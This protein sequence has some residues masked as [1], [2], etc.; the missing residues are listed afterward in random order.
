MERWGVDKEHDKCAACK[1]PQK[2]V[3]IANKGFPEWELEFRLDRKNLCGA[4]LMDVKY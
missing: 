1:D 3:L 2:V 4:N